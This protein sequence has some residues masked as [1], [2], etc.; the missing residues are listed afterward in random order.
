MRLFSEQINNDIK[1][2]DSIEDTYKCHMDKD[3]I[4]NVKTMIYENEIID[5]TN[6]ISCNS[7]DTDKN[8]SL[9]E[10][11]NPVEDPVPDEVPHEVTVE[12]PHEVTVEDPVEDP[13]EAP[14][15][16]TVEIIQEN[17][18]VKVAK[19]RGRPRKL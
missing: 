4:E 16:A 17:E 15:D 13:V 2:D 8:D 7:S 18:L 12:V 1:F 10:F 9:E 19:R 5:F 11:T 6:I 3:T 14:D